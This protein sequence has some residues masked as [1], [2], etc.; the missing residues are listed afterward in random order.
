MVDTDYGLA[1]SDVALADAGGP[2]GAPDL[3]IGRIP[4]SSPSEL[5]AV[6]AKIRAYESA[7][8]AW[9][10]TVLLTA[11]GADSGGDFPADSDRL[12]ESLPSSLRIRT[13]Y[14]GRDTV[15]Q[16]RAGI[17][18]A[19]ANG[20]L[21][22]NYLGHGAVDRLAQEG[23]L[24]TTDVGSLA[25]NARLPLVTLL[26]CVAGQYGLPG[27]DGLSEAL[28]M[29]PGAGAIAVWSPS[30]PELNTYSVRLSELFN[31]NLFGASHAPVLGEIVQA[32][33]AAAA[34]QGLP[35]STLRTYV[36]LGDPALRVRW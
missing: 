19:F 15:A 8:G 2:A 18:D 34:V 23:L 16:T 5:D 32:A 1:P 12:A 6:I 9:R 22:F 24:T 29:R 17:F 33:H 35:D 28:V 14:L 21:L 30:A 26:T 25:T 10:Q 36:L 4:A 27:A 31:E 11:D 3:A 20:A 13:A 7:D